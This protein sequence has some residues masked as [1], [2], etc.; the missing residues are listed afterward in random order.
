MP[1]ALPVSEV[2]TYRLIEELVS[3]QGWKGSGARLLAQQ[4]Y[5]GIASLKTA[6][7]RASKT[8][9]GIGFPEYVLLR[10]QDE[11][12]LAV[13]EGKARASEITKA[14]K[15]ATHY[16]D[17]LYEA[18]FQ[19]LAV[20]VAG[21]EDAHFEVRVL[22]RKGSGS[23]LQPSAPGRSR[24]AGPRQRTERHA[25]VWWRIVRRRVTWRRI[26]G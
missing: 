17:A 18:G 7:A 20:A 12:P 22:K 15:E 10:V 5:R 11:Q 3:I 26:V 21:T 13:F 4:E 8:G 1:R 24:H 25:S 2:R 16:A 14:I 19:P 6:L 23:T 9:A